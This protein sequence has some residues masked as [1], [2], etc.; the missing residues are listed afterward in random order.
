VANYITVLH[1]GRVFMEG[2]ANEVR[3]NA[4]V[5]EIYFGEE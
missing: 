1:E 2:S 4:K 3:G 5:Q